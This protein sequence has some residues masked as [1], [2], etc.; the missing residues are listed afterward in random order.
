MRSGSLIGLT[1]S[2]HLIKLGQTARDKLHAC[3]TPLNHKGVL[4]SL[5]MRNKLIS[6][7]C[8]ENRKVWGARSLHTSWSKSTKEDRFIRN[9]ESTDTSDL[10]KLGFVISSGKKISNILV[11]VGAV[12]NLMAAYDTIKSKPGNITVGVRN[13][14]LDGISKIKLEKLSSELIRGRFKFQPSRRVIIPKK[15]GGER[16]LS[17]PSPIDKIVHQAI[18]QQ[19]ELV[20]DPLFLECSH[21]FRTGRGCHTAFNQIK[22]K[23]G[24]VN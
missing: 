20:F 1:P 16:P 13:E 23:F 18:K 21:G 8:P 5:P 15:S 7:G 14:T 2:T 10:K 3:R 4:L 6:I 12:D 9:L 19:L 17:I 11:K 24:G 22:M